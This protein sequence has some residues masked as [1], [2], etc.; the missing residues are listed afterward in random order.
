MN[1]FIHKNHIL[2]LAQFHFL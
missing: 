2:P 1:S